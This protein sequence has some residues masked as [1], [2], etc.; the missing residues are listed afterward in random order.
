MKNVML[1]LGL[2][3]SICSCA[4][5]QTPQSE[6]QQTSRVPAQQSPAPKK[7]EKFRLVSYKDGVLKIE[8][9]TCGGRVKPT[10]TFKPIEEYTDP[11]L[12]YGSYHA[13]IGKSEELPPK[14][15]CPFLAEHPIEINLKQHLKDWSDSEQGTEA[16]KTVFK[17]RGT[18]EI[19]VAPFETDIDYQG[20]VE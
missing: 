18:I 5:A 12:M 11:G 16:S 2:M 19:L 15:F 3:V 8:M 10:V 14:T 6:V 13:V 4:I 7:L 20:R 9:S 1:T 17:S